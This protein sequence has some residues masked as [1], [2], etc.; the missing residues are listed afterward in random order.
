MQGPGC[1]SGAQHIIGLVGHPALQAL[2]PSA[3]R[4]GGAWGGG[5]VAKD[6]QRLSRG[7]CCSGLHRWRTACEPHRV[8][9]R[10]A[11]RLHHAPLPVKS[12]CLQ[13]REGVLCWTCCHSSDVSFCT[14]RYCKLLNPAVVVEEGISARVLFFYNLR[15]FH[16]EVFLP[17]VELLLISFRFLGDFFFF[18]SPF[19]VFWPAALQP[20]DRKTGENFHNWNFWLAFIS[21]C[22]CGPRCQ[23]RWPRLTRLLLPKLC[24]CLLTEVNSAGT[25]VLLTRGGMR[26]L[27]FHSQCSHAL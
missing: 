15:F 9:I 1:D 18:P 17:Q 12:P 13:R 10:R 22:F 20:H 5:G 14:E 4:S 19:F 23:D 25:V 24:K 27:W 16:Q 11:E 2:N 26:S 21:F 8:A 7:V 6:G 3:G